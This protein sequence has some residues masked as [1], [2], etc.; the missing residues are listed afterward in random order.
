MGLDPLADGAHDCWRS[1][2]DRA[3]WII[4]DGLASYDRHKLEALTDMAIGLLDMFDGDPDLEDDDPAG[5]NVEDEG[6]NAGVLSHPSRIRR[7]P[8]QGLYQPA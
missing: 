5:G 8:D 4:G 2:L 1:H 3:R 7:G 6:E